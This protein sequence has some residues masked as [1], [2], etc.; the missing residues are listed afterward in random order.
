MQDL[1]QTDSAW[2]CTQATSGYF[3]AFR[4]NAQGGIECMSTDSKDCIWTK[5]LSDCLKNITE[6][7]TN[8]NLLT[9]GAMH[10]SLYGVTG[11]DD[12]SHWCY[13]SCEILG[14]SIPTSNRL[15]MAILASNTT[16]ETITA[17]PPAAAPTS[18]TIT[19]PPR[20]GADTKTSDESKA[21]NSTPLIIALCAAGVLIVVLLAITFYLV[22][23]RKNKKHTNDIICDEL[24][25][26]DDSTFQTVNDSTYQPMNETT[27][28]TDVQE[29]TLS[30]VSIPDRVIG[31]QLDFGDLAMWR[32]D[33]YHL[34]P[35]KML[36]KG[37][38]GEVWLGKYKNQTVAI[39]KL[40]NYN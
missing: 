33:E 22:R 6:F 23:K 8:L 35:I 20:S 17:P 31:A 30:N 27:Y 15:T 37:A 1:Q 39:K 18:A 32:L 34:V 38:N 24:A 12:K 13:K 40:L 9:C 10:N 26:V 14:I 2:K 21:S 11:Y 19:Y 28:Q 3:Y 29:A 16:D 5:S 25:T 36:A 4:Q 7:P